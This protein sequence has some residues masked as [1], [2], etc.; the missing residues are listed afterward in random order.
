[1]SLFPL[2]ISSKDEEFPVEELA[3]HMAAFR[4]SVKFVKSCMVEVSSSVVIL[5]LKNRLAKP[6]TNLY[7][8]SKR[9]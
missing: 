2:L 7:E 6:S 8:K 3:A 5:S 4:E 9:Y 1:M